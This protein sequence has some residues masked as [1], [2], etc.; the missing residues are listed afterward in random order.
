MSLLG[1][2]LCGLGLGYAVHK[3]NQ[4][5]AGMKQNYLNTYGQPLLESDKEKIYK[6]NFY[7]V[8]NYFNEQF[9]YYF[10][11]YDVVAQK[12]NFSQKTRELQNLEREFVLRSNCGFLAYADIISK[13]APDWYSKYDKYVDP[14]Y[15]SSC[16]MLSGGKLEYYSNYSPEIIDAIANGLTG[17]QIHNMG[18]LATH[19]FTTQTPFDIPALYFHGRYGR[20]WM[21]DIIGYSDD[22]DPDPKWHKLRRGWDNKIVDAWCADP[23]TYDL[24]KPNRNRTKP[25]TEI[26][27]ENRGHFELYKKAK[28][29]GKIK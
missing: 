18:G 16:L 5:F 11:N 19:Q 22:I 29:E 21:S 10:N 13:F 24:K 8:L 26:N 6:E 23:E 2:L 14:S 27:E 4:K 7:K 20:P 25:Y 17:R 15:T 1:L 28:Q 12:M 3:D 9:D